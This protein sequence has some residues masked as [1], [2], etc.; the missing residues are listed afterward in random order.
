M[1]NREL[2]INKIEHIEAQLKVL[3]GIVTRNE[4][5]ST[6]KITI[7]KISDILEDVKSMISR[8]PLSPQEGNG[9]Q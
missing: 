5:V 2:I 9:L 6:Y 8:E 3:E 1:R 4:P 7:N